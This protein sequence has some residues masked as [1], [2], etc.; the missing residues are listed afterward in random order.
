MKQSY[1]ILFVL[2]SL[3][4][5]LGAQTSVQ[6]VL[7]EEHTGAWCGYCVDGHVI[8]DNVLSTYPNAI[9]VMVHNGDGMDFSAGNTVANFYVG[10]FPQA[11]INRS[12][13]AIS[14][15]AWMSTTSAQLSAGPSSVEVSF[16]SVLYNPTTR[17]LN[18]FV[19]AK[20]TGNESG[21]LRFNGILV[22]DGV[23]GTGS[24][25]NQTNYYNGTSGHPMY[26]LGNP[27]V[28]YVHDKVAR[29]YFGGAWG[30]VGTLPTT[31]TAGEEYTHR[32]I[33]NV[34]ASVDDTKMWVVGMVSRYDGTGTTQ[35]KII[36]ANSTS[37][38]TLV[39]YNVSI[40]EVKES[41]NAIYPN[42]TSGIFNVNPAIDG[43]HELSIIN[44]TGQTIFTQ[45]YTTTAG[46]PVTIDITSQP[47]GI[48]M[49]KFGNTVQRIVKQ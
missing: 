1:T 32:F 31:I 34:P 42:P 9:G 29:A 5:G 13:D 21:N 45:I 18:V 20:F 4:L 28:G 24:D 39:N 36:N 49:V 33:Y 15:S 7:I 43:E 16:D 41:I 11:T 10:G 6:K 30:T 35:R 8:L 37:N 44:S 14:R 12:S 47:A 27:I 40:D 2:I 17:K 26:G 3:S 25:Y 23:T 22:E 48:Y 19:R 46:T 38:I